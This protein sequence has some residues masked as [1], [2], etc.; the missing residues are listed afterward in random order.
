MVGRTS[1]TFAVPQPLPSSSAHVIGTARMRRAVMSNDGGADANA[2]PADKPP[3]GRWSGV[4]A[5]AQVRAPTVHA[6]TRIHLIPV[7]DARRL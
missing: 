7:Q 2:V 5:A 3:S 1:A 6:R 4:E